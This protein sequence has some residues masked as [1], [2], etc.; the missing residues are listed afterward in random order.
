MILLALLLLT[1]YIITILKISEGLSSVKRYLPKSNPSTFISIIVP[2]KNEATNLPY[3]L[4]SIYN[5]DYDPANYELIVVNDNSSDATT[6]IALSFNKIANMHV[7]SNT[8]VGKKA[9]IRS[10]VEEA[11]GE[12]IV[13]CDADCQM[14]NSWLRTI[15]DYYEKRHPDMIVCPVKLEGDGFASWFQKLEFASLQ[16]VTAGTIMKNNAIMC[17]GANLAFTK[18]VYEQN[19]ENLYNNLPSGDDIFLLQSIKKDKDRI[20]DWL[21]SDN[22]IVTTGCSSTLDSYLSQ[23][24]RWISKTGYYNDMYTI[25]VS[26]VTLIAV[27]LQFTL[28][29][30]TLYDTVFFKAFATTF[31]VKSI[32]DYMIISNVAKR[33]GQK[34]A[35]KCFLPA[36]LVYPFYVIATILKSLF[37]NNFFGKR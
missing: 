24:A 26:L 13:T 14:P 8:G 20:I 32:P 18:E 17:N 27:I 25:F 29:I 7:I 21:E 31:L 34:S 30:M 3:L 36:Q 6:S 16:G 12:L 11:K 37:G 5:Q 33:Y 9:A 1:P 23:R 10:G 22:V 28:C 35:L 4:E 19:S 2:C 15:A